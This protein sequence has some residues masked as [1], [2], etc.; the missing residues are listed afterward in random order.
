[1]VKSKGQSVNIELEIGINSKKSK[2]KSSI[3]GNRTKRSKNSV[4]EDFEE[5]KNV[6]ND[7]EFISNPDKRLPGKVLVSY[8]YDVI[9]D[10][11]G[12]LNDV[13][14]EIFRQSPFSTMYTTDSTLEY[15][16]ICY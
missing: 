1:M 15:L 11:R 9:Y 10:I 12:K 2:R 4:Q 8:S 3:S 13:Q 5:L 14:Q 16:D 7:G 6:R